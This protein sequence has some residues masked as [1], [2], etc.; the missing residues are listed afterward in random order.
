MAANFDYLFVWSDLMK[1]ELQQF[2]YTSI[3]KK[4][5]IEVVGTPQFEPYVLDR[6]MSLKNHFFEKFD[7]DLNKKKQF[8][9]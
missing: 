2:F 9:F 1:I 5:N 3:K 8:V 6:Y 7:L 4:K